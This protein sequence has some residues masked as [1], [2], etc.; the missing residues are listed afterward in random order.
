[1]YMYWKASTSLTL[2]SNMPESNFAMHSWAKIGLY[3]MQQY[4]LVLEWGMYQRSRALENQKE[5]MPTFTH[6]VGG[7]GLVVTDK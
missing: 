5:I 4:P 1:M 7:G 6:Q 2:N 3:P